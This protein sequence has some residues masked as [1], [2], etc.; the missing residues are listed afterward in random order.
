MADI[1]ITIIHYK[2]PPPWWY[3]SR[4]YRA[5]ILLQ[6]SPRLRGLQWFMRTR[7][8]GNKTIIL[9]AI[10]DMHTE[11][12]GGERRAGEEWE[13]EDEDGSS[14]LGESILRPK[15]VSLKFPSFPSDFVPRL[16]ST[17]AHH[18]PSAHTQLDQIDDL[19]L[20]IG[21]TSP[22]RYRIIRLLGPCRK[23]SE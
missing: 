9:E 2:P 17:I 20:G 7:R 12:D 21:S 14:G 8:L 23:S 11:H 19:R 16:S 1:V 15:Q 22:I 4:A 5:P 10:Y 18:L 6:S 3:F 13:R